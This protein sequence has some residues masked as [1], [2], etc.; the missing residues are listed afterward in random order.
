MSPGN[1]EAVKVESSGLTTFSNMITTKNA[2]IEAQLSQH[3]AL[4]FEGY[5]ATTPSWVKIPFD[6]QGPI[7]SRPSNA[8]GDRFLPQFS[9]FDIRRQGVYATKAHITLDFTSGLQSRNWNGQL[10]F[11]FMFHP[12]NKPTEPQI[13]YETDHLHLNWT[14]Y[15]R[16]V[17]DEGLSWTNC[18]S[19]TRMTGFG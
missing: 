1:V 15:D 13:R 4:F 10:L 7:Q 19:S 5:N 2:W 3:F 9:A 18:L 6:I 14:R 17:M 8:F 12:V 16:V 11:G